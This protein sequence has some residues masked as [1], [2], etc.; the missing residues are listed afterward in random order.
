MIREGY[1]VNETIT[2]GEGH[3]SSKQDRSDRTMRLY[4]LHLVTEDDCDSQGMPLL[5]AVDMNLDGYELVS[6]KSKPSK[7]VGV[8]FFLEDYAFENTWRDPERYAS[9]LSKFAFTLTPDYSVFLEMPEPMQRWNIYRSRAV[10]RI[11]QNAGLTVIPTVSWGLANTYDFAF[12]GIRDGSTLAFSSVGLMR[13]EEGRQ[14][15]REGAEAACE[16]LRPKQI[17]CY[18]VPCEFDARGAVVHWVQSEMQ[19]RFDTIKK[20]S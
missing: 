4:N 13:C 7:E 11:W 12:D 19:K 1:N 5:D 17:I 14:I 10:G 9:M 6:F 3:V 8:H 15:F 18:G 20:E 16:Y 2:S